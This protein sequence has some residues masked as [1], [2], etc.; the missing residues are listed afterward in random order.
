MMTRA[1]CCGEDNSIA[2]GSAALCDDAVL[3]WHTSGQQGLI[4]GASVWQDQLLEGGG[5]KELMAAAIEGGDSAGGALEAGDV[6]V[7]DE[8]A[9]WEL[10]LVRRREGQ[11]LHLMRF[12][13]HGGY[14]ALN[15]ETCGEFTG[16]E[17]TGSCGGSSSI[18]SSKMCTVVLAFAVDIA[19][20]LSS[21]PSS[22][23]LSAIRFACGYDDGTSLYPAHVTLPSS[24]VTLLT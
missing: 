17:Q 13:W 16:S 12:E 24:H 4:L 21:S 6:L 19:P 1:H 9:G 14:G 2:D 10:F 3:I 22:S 11:G 20:P 23:T 7:Q 5:R 15:M 18:K 8:G